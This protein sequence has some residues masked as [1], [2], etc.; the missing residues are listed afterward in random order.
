MLNRE[1]KIETNQSIEHAIKSIC[2]LFKLR[3]I[4]YRKE[5]SSL[6]SEYIPISFMMINWDNRLYSRDN[7]IGVNP[8]LFIDSIRVDFS[9]G[10]N[11]V[12]IL[13]IIV[14][15]SRSL[16]PIIF[17]IPILMYP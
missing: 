9:S 16:I 10:H 15:R 1:F 4:G 11:G 14:S 6:I 17:M 12:T 3:S 2:T 8:F 5:N 13:N 7:F